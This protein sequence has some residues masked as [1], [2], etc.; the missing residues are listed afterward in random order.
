VQQLKPGFWKVV[1]H[2]GFMEDPDVPAL[3][4]AAIDQGLDVEVRQATFFV[5]REQLVPARKGPWRGFPQWLFALM[6]RNARP[7]PDFFHL[8]PNRVMEVGAQLQL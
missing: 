1:G 7:A 8:P 2:Y 4:E 5:G 3:L 6:H